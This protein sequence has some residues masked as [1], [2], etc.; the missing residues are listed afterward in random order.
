MKTVELPQYILLILIQPTPPAVGPPHPGRNWMAHGIYLSEEECVK[1]LM[2]MP[3]FTDYRII[4]TR[5]PTFILSESEVTEQLELPFEEAYTFT[6]DS[7]NAEK[8]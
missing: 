7:P 6:E 5:L 1:E 2:L 8:E 3:G 4:K